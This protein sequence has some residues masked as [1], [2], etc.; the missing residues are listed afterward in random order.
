[1]SDKPSSIKNESNT[2]G[3]AY[4]YLLPAGIILLV[5]WL[6]PVILSLLV[7]FTNWYGGDTASDVRWVGWKNYTRAIADPRFRQTLW[8]TV[9]YVLWSV[10]LT[11][12]L[13]LGSALLLNMRIRGVAF[14]RTI[15]FLPYVTTW[16]AI[17]IVWM[18]I[19]QRNSGIANYVLG[20]FLGW[21]RLDWLIEPR[22]VVEMSLT[23]LG[24]LL[25]ILA[26]DDKIALANPI[27]AGPSLSMFSIILTSVWRDAGYFMI[28]FLA[29]LKNIDASLREAAAIDGA[30]PWQR[31]RAI[32]L[33]LLSPITFF[34]AI[35][36][37]IQAFKVFVPMM[38]MTPGGGPSFTTST[39]VYYLYDEGF[40]SWRLGY[41]SAIAY[42]LFIVILAITLLQNRVFG[43]R[44]FY[45]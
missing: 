20:D 14:F 5:F 6:L 30:G 1:M 45:Q 7:S 3:R 16:V 4:L 8:N 21:G 32:T 36:A 42:L 31:F 10:P 38:I 43:R 35:M 24:H 27:L 25:G 17:S 12:L 13:S 44:V 40:H 29:G 19:F 39:M 23:G 37:V 9:N 28:I 15:F 2:G 22:G 18:Y 34:V 11:I 41:A 26:P 33:P